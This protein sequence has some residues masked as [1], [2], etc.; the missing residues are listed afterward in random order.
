MELIEYI[1]N[2]NIEE[3]KSVLNNNNDIIFSNI[4]IQQAY[5]YSMLIKRLELFN[6]F[7]N[8][9]R[10]DPSVNNNQVFNYAVYLSSFN[11]VKI[12]LL[13]KRIN[14]TDNFYDL[15]FN[16]QLNG[17]LDSKIYMDLLLNHPNTDFNKVLETNILFKKQYKKDIINEISDTINTFIINKRNKIITD[18]IK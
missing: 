14:P 9:S 12:L 13:D 1:Y 5:T 10:F 2:N 17:I 7:L 16:L 15:I 4:E 8:D 6:L 3:I 18:L 11:Y